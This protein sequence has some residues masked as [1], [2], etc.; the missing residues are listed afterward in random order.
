[1]LMPNNGSSHFPVIFEF[2]KIS[3]LYFQTYT[4]AKN[5]IKWTLR[6]LSLSFNDDQLMAN[7]FLSIL[8]PIPSTHFILK[9]VPD[10]IYFICK[11]LSMHLSFFLFSTE[12]RIFGFPC[13]LWFFGEIRIINQVSRFN[14]HGKF[15]GI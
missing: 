11:Y 3:S 1:M 12:K 9:P 2:K 4:Q 8:L 13:Y 10:T 15:L 5:I 7:L 14:V 6:F